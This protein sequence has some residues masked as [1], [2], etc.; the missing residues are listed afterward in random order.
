M[1]P[2]WVILF[3]MLFLPGFTQEK[4]KK[5]IT[6]KLDLKIFSNDAE[7][8]Q[9]FEKEYKAYHPD[10]SVLND[11]RDRLIKKQIVV[12]LGTWCSDSQREFPRLMKVL[13]L[14]QFPMAGLRIYG[15]NNNKSLP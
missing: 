9:W 6:G 4:F 8:K 2:V 11:L 7:L 15:V 10:S 5:V 1:K 13:D 3:S 14:L 12:V